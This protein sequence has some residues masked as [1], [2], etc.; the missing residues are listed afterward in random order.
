M[1]GKS[2]KTNTYTI[3]IMNIHKKVIIVLKNNIKLWDLQSSV[4]NKPDLQWGLNNVD[5]YCAT[6]DTSQPW[7]HPF[8]GLIPCL[9]Y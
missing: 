1:Y 9:L 4:A 6:S 5:Y 7:K 2:N 3:M 8:L